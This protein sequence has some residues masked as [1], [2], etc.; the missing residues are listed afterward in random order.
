MDSLLFRKSFTQY[1]VVAATVFSLSGC[2]IHVGGGGNSSSG[3]NGVSSVFGGLEISEG[4]QVS[5]VSSVNGSIELNDS[6]TAN[7]VDTV[8]G[9]IEIGDFVTVESAN[10]VNGDIEAGKHFTSFG[11]VETVNGDIE[12]RQASVL[13]Q[14][15]E[16]VNGDI[17]IDGSE[18]KGSL[19]THNGDVIL[20]NNSKILGDIVYHS[21][22][23]KQRYNS[24]PTLTIKQGS[25][26]EGQII[27][28]REVELDIEDAELL[29]KVS[30]QYDEK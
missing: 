11:N 12:I 22:H 23:R 30:Y 3:G 26:V 29:R 6:V 28:Q 10:T 14:N 5:N 2:I 21:N 7:A 24:I 1:A 4:K 8:N 20:Q 9:S 13:H 19:H 18:V 16:T 27:L 17:R 25:I 15:A